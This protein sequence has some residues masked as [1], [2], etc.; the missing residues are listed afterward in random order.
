[1]TA[2]VDRVFFFTK[3]LLSDRKAIT[4]SQLPAIIHVRYIPVPANEKKV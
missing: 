2:F 4:K 3:H 1:M